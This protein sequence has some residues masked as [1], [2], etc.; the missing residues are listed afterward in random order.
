MRR[1]EK[2]LV[3]TKLLP[4]Y[5]CFHSNLHHS[6]PCI[7]YHI[8]PQSTNTAE[9]ATIDPS[10]PPPPVSNRSASGGIPPPSASTQSIPRP[11]SRRSNITSQLYQFALGYPQTPPETSPV[12]D[13]IGPSTSVGSSGTGNSMGS[14]LFKWY[15]DVPYAHR[16]KELNSSDCTSCHCS[17]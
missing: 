11:A 16:T 5:F 9:V 3:V 2:L 15:V 4:S 13:P 12:F 14:F 17:A 1:W 10:S 8:N 7:C 6:I